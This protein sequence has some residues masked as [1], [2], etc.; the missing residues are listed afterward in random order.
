MEWRRKRNNKTVFWNRSRKS[1]VEFDIE[2]KSGEEEE[3]EKEEEIWGWCGKEQRAERERGKEKENQKEFISRSPVTLSLSITN[4]Q[5]ALCLSVCVWSFLQNFKKPLKNVKMSQ[6]IQKKVLPW[7]QI[8]L[9]NKLVNLF[10]YLFFSFCDRWRRIEK[11]K[12]QKTKF[13][14]RRSNTFL[15]FYN[16]HTWAG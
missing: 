12:K 10:S 1:R 7:K 13:P 3:E 14:V 16:K 4:K 15:S 11:N 8:D 2:P 6:T 9:S 5:C